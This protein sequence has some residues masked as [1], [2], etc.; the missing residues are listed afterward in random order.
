[1]MD[2][3]AAS[4]WLSMLPSKS[5]HRIAISYRRADSSGISGRIFDRL[6]AHYG[7]GAVFMDIDH[8]PFGVDFRSHV[9]DTLLQTDILLAV[10]GAN[11]IG[12]DTAGHARIREEMDPVKVEIAMALEQH[13][14]I[15]PVLVDGAKMPRSTE[16]PPEFANF[17]FL[18][19]AEVSSG[20]DFHHHMDRLINAIDRALATDGSVIT[21][22]SPSSSARGKFASTKALTQTPWQDAALRYF[23]VP[24]LLLLIT[25]HVIVHVL[26]LNTK[27][28]WVISPFVPFLSG[29]ALFWFGNRGIGSAS[30]FALALGAVGVAG[31]TI[32]E[33]LNS[34]DPLLPQTR[35]EWRENVQFV[36]V[37]ALSL[38]AGH[39][40]ARGIRAVIKRT[41]ADRME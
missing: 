22:Y 16:L 19:A 24:L 38:V 32:S 23:V 30:I 29:F 37:I 1:M 26:D 27:Y 31:M 10:I 3:S 21:P 28:L 9:H 7:E 5:S 18:N 25:H 11:W 12:V 17:S 41:P 14:T 15:I 33:S 4:N 8:I 35:F 36:V 2:A 6:A 20:R 39:A 13:T 40:F 34:G